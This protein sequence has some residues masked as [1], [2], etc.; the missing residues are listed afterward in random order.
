MRAA[1]TEWIFFKRRAWCLH[2]PLEFSQIDST[3]RTFYIPFSSDSLALSKQLGSKDD[4][5]LRMLYQEAVSV[6]L[7]QEVYNASPAQAREF[8][9]VLNY[10]T[11]KM[12]ERDEELYRHALDVLQ[13]TWHFLRLLHIPKELSIHIRLAA[14][15]HDIGKLG[16]SQE[17]LS[18]PVRLTPQEHNEVKKH[19]DYGATL[20][21]GTQALRPMATMVRHHHE[22]WD[23]AGYP[24]GMQGIT[25]PLG[26]RII[27]I[28]D[29][30]AVMTSQ[31]CYHQP[32]TPAEALSELS[33]CAGSQF[34]PLLV[35]HFCL[36][37]EVE[38][39]LEPEAVCAH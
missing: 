2:I 9:F 14:F 12:R 3:A 8:L 20:L 6:L 19:T 30:Y 15:F 18:K 28:A 13:I 37:Q 1:R 21:H 17:L 26:S 25:I 5:L 16:I 34:D 36:S 7:P 23:G 22:R 4:L 10:M 31:R 11:R 29:A 35:Q 33:Q 39:A 38:P 24:C 27:A 32:C